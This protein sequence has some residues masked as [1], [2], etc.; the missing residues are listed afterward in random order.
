VTGT[1]GWIVAQSAA[2]AGGIWFGIWLF[3]A[4][5]R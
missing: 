4:I 5:T 1:W 2:V 3:D